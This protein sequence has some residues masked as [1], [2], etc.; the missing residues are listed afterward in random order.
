MGLFAFLISYV[1][2][3]FLITSPLTSYADQIRSIHVTKSSQGFSLDTPLIMLVAS[4]LRCFY[5]LGAEFETS[6]L[7]QSIIMIGV[8]TV[9]L[10]VALDNRPSID[11]APFATAAVSM[12]PYDFWQWRSQRPFWTF[13]LYFT[14][15]TTT[16][17]LLLGS[18]PLFVDTLGYLA[19]GIEAALPLPQVLAN[20]KAKSCHGFRVSLLAAWLLGDVMKTIFFF[21][22]EK[23][24]LQFK[25]CA[26]VQFVLDA[27][28]G[29]Q[30][31]MF[32][33]GEGKKEEKEM[34]VV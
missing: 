20:H 9:L 2:P 14:L 3:L 12:R 10:K 25:I 30:F 8:Q 15:T 1:A 29:V 6:L 18:S 22:A 24:G 28:L 5:W 34:R 21:N 26:A 7:I 11:S 16:L 4:I 27:F 23:V 32:G 17:Q 19:L 13:L 33:A 31:W